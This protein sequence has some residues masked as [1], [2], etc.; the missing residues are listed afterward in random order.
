MFDTRDQGKGNRA[1]ALS[2]QFDLTPDQVAE[3]IQGPPASGLFGGLRNRMMGKMAGMFA[4]QLSGPT[5]LVVDAS[6]I[7]R[8][9][10]G[11]TV[12]LPWAEIASVN[13]RPTAWMV[14]LK[15]NGILMIPFGAVAD[16]DRPAFEAELRTLAG[17][18]YRVRPR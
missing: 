8:T 10:H 6:G 17:A 14:Q 2:V 9:Q 5:A 4:Q 1:V 13:E 11:I 7:T 15:P 16:A 18:K 3:V 12:P